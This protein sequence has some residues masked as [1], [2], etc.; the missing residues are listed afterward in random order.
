MTK[1]AYKLHT[2]PSFISNK[3]FCRIFM[4]VRQHSFS[5]R[6]IHCVL[7]EF[8]TQRTGKSFICEE[9]PATYIKEGESPVF[10]S[11]RGFY[12]HNSFTFYCPLLL[13]SKEK[14]VVFARAP[15]LIATKEE[16]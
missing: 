10:P 2:R 9:V 12:F 14:R 5:N 7:Q 4:L 11:V 16:T 6:K 8:L 13:L 15:P 1:D 3:D